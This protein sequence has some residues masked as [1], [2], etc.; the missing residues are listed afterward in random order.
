M[1]HLIANL[2]SE[3]DS[4][5]VGTQPLLLWRPSDAEKLVLE[6]TQAEFG[7]DERLPYWAILWPASIA[8]ANHVSGLDGIAGKR[9]LELGAGLGVPGLAAARAGARV[10]VT[11][12]YAEALDFV[13]S[14]A[15]LN[16]L[17]LETRHLDWRYPPDDEQFDYI[18]GADLV[19]ERR[20]HAPI[21]A[22]AAKLL[23][24]SGKLLV[25]DPERLPG[26]LFIETAQAEG[27]HCSATRQVVAWDGAAFV[28]NCWELGRG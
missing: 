1:P 15:R 22:C 27:W 21:L 17:T 4:V 26:Q 11:D 16:G 14:S 3:T 10:V 23:A 12:W 2:P 7:E 18:L 25:S 28:T 6:T 20:S 24:P 13:Q 19:Y 8:L 5:L 9:V